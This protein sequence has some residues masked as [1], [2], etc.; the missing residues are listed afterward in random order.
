MPRHPIKVEF[1]EVV[2]YFT[3]TESD[4]WQYHE[5]YDFHYCEDYNTICVYRVS[6]GVADVSKAVHVHYLA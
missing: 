2:Y 5:G 3:P 4:E 6:D 1:G